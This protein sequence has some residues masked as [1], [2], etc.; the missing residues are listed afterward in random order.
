MAFEVGD[1]CQFQGFEVVRLV[2]RVLQV[3]I[4]ARGFDRS[5][6]VEAGCIFADGPGSSAVESGLDL[7]AVGHCDLDQILEGLGVV[8]E[9]DFARHAG[10]FDFSANRF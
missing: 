9:G 7:G 2:K 8:D 1:S 4:A 10:A 6:F 3:G 5:V